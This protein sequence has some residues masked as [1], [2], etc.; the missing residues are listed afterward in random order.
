[1][2]TMTGLKWICNF[3]L[4]SI[5]LELTACNKSDSV[6]SEVNTQDPVHN[7]Q[8]QDLTFDQ[9]INGFGRFESSI[10]LARDPK[11]SNLLAS[12]SVTVKM[13]EHILSSFCSTDEMKTSSLNKLS[14]SG[15]ECDLQGQIQM[16]IDPKRS[17]YKVES[18]LTIKD[19]SLA[20]LNI[21]KDLDLKGNGRLKSTIIDS[22]SSTLEANIG[23]KATAHS[24]NWG[25][26][27]LD[28][29]V[30]QNQQIIKGKAKAMSGERILRIV[31]KNS[32]LDIT[33]RSITS[34]KM[35]EANVN[36]Q[37]VNASDIETLQKDDSQYLLN[38]QP[39]S[40]ELYLNYYNR[41]GMLLDVPGLL[42]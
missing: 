25:L 24:A 12:D 1:M 7:K 13:K 32:N 36:S 40:K 30:V 19:S 26:I 20:E 14:I 21:I 11:F 33:L 16:S 8:T 29:S 15:L 5:A 41:L 9:L 42:Y 22:S 4:L 28:Y 2:N 27:N 38:N 34:V 35:I 3:L 31:A 39:I 17:F 37:D 23:I 10:R 6:P 18:V